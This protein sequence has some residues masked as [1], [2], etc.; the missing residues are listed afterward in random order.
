MLSINISVNA[1]LCF[2]LINHKKNTVLLE[3]ST[4]PAVNKPTT[5]N[6]VGS[7]R[8][9]FSSPLTLALLNSWPKLKE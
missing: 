7:K 2:I 8:I 5:G 4:A 9:C 6:A 1:Y 3:C